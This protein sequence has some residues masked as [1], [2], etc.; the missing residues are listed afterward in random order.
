MANPDIANGFSFVRSLSGQMV[1]MRGRV[2]INQIIAKGD[3]L[4]ISAGGLLQIG[5]FDSDEIY[6]VANTPITT[7]GT[8]DETDTIEFYPATDQIIFEAQVS[9]STTIALI[10]D[11]VDIEGATGVMEVN[12]NA[13]VEEVFKIIGLASDKRE[14][15]D[16]GLNDRVYG[17]FTRSSYNRYRGAK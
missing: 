9:G 2:D 5:L 7:T 11:D 12:E 1:P 13:V 14:E 4:I 8:V 15:L 10:G 3:A 17:Y 6:G 16:L